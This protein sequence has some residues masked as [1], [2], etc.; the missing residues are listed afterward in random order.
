MNDYKTIAESR[1]FI[2][3]DKYAREWKAAESYQSESDLERELVRDLVSQGYELA[4]GIKSG[5]DLLANVRTQLEALNAVQFADGEW[6]RF[7]ETWLDKPSDGIVEFTMTTFTTSS[8]TMGA[9][10]TSTCSTRR[11]SRATRCR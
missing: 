10:R 3:L 6:S 11:T 1:N 9:S 8:L 2:V 7:V 5:A 4:S